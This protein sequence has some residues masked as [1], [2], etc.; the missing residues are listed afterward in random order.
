MH[1][2]YGLYGHFV[3]QKV[4]VTPCAHVPC[5][6][7]S[8][9]CHAWVWV[10]KP[11]GKLRRCEVSKLT[12]ILT[13]GMTGRIGVALFVEHNFLDCP[14]IWSNWT[15]THIFRVGWK[16]NTLECYLFWEVPKKKPSLWQGPHAY[17]GVETLIGDGNQPKSR[18]LCTHYRDF[19]IPTKGWVTIPNIKSLDPG[20]HMVCLPAH[21]GS[22]GPVNAGKCRPVPLS[23]GRVFDLLEDSN[24]QWKNLGCLM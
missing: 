23:V 20:S 1:G 17:A 5:R 16:K 4:W 2:S 14:K 11:L 8:P 12:R 22:F 19:R 9:S 3:K 13:F 15:C 24:E 7:E 6:R 21:L 10:G 18:G